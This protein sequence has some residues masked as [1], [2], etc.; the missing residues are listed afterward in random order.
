MKSARIVNSNLVTETRFMYNC[1]LYGNCEELILQ[2]DQIHLSPDL[3]AWWF[4]IRD[5][6]LLVTLGQQPVPFGCLAELPFPDIDLT[7]CILVG[8]Y[9]GA[10]AYLISLTEPDR[11]MGLGEFHGL[12]FLLGKVHDDLFNLAGRAFQIVNFLATH[13][14]CGQ[15]GKQMH[16]ID[17]ELAM[18]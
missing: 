4:V 3:L 12:R 11:D 15:C 13:Q 8:E 17:W 1:E 16:R 5:G 2:N 10:P 9:D 14:F 7:Q 18:K 6:Q